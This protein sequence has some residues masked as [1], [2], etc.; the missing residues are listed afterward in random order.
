MSLNA[1]R[2]LTTHH[3]GKYKPLLSLGLAWAYLVV[4][5]KLAWPNPAWT[6]WGAAPRL[7][8]WVAWA[9]RRQ[10]VEAF[11]LNL[12]E[13]T[14]PIMTIWKRLKTWSTAQ[15]VWLSLCASS[16]VC[17]RRF[18]YPWSGCSTNTSSPHGVTSTP[19]ALS[20]LALPQLSHQKQSSE[21]FYL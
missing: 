1:T 8:A 9:W 19:K 15:R 12:H 17:H 3:L 4:V 7:R 18:G 2:R 6:N 11:S 20:S 21:D 13:F 5:S 14:I 16:W 10:W